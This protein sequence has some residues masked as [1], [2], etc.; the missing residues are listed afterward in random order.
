MI[1]ILWNKLKASRKD[2]KGQVRRKA[3]NAE[4]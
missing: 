2:A 4:P 1:L 3:E